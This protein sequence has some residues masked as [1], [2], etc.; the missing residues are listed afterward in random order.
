MNEVD[1]KNI[2]GIRRR[3]LI[4]SFMLTQYFYRLVSMKE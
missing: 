3:F 2:P 1:E 4:A